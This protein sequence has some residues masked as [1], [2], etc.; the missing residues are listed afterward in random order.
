MTGYAFRRYGQFETSPEAIEQELRSAVCDRF[1]ENYSI[2]IDLILGQI[3]TVDTNRVR[4]MCDLSKNTAA[5]ASIFL[6]A[7]LKMA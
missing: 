1:K 3:C 6:P 2:D 7:M 4:A 5:V